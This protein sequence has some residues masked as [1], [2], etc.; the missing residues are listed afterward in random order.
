MGDRMHRQGTCTER[1]L[2]YSAPMTQT[3]AFQGEAGAYSDMAAQEAMPGC[4]TTACPSFDAA[5]TAVREG[6]ADLAMIPV[7][8]TVAGRVA[9]VHHLMPDGEL[10]IIGEWFLPVRHCLLAPK[11]A[12][13]SGLR[14]VHSHIH[15]LPQCRK[16]IESMGLIAHIHA[17]TAGAARQIAQQ[18][19]PAHGAIASTL[20]ARIYGLDILAQDMQDAEHNTTRFLI[21]A[22]EPRI[23]DPDEGPVLTTLI[24]E[25]RNLP[26]A[27]YKALGGFA[28]NGLSLA[29]LESYVDPHFQAA[30][31]YCDIEGH[32]ETPAFRRAIE[33]LGFFAQDVKFLGTY[34]THPFRQ[35]QKRA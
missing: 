22:T 14:H 2:V 4:I 32:P 20:A 15:A 25:I 13:L 11:G 9:D 1:G 7:D 18:G 21:L 31:F 19:D 24:F 6:T 5:F 29:K 33:E 3:I 30:R 12:P 17:D 34:P 27:L 28:T 26:A 23:P 10:Y 35:S 8:N 16:S